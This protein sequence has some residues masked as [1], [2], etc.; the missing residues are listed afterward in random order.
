MNATVSISLNVLAW[1]TTGA[2]ALGMLIAS[3]T[4]ALIKNVKPGDNLLED[5]AECQI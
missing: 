5:E 3:V 4:N 1:G 2:I